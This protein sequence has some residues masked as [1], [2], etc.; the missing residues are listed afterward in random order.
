MAV[1]QNLC[2][3]RD[4]PT[5]NEPQQ[6]GKRERECEREREE[7]WAGRSAGRHING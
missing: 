6:Q 3:K 7:G 2:N 5:K 1:F 4:R